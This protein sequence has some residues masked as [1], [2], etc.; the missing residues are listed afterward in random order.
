MGNDV[1]EILDNVTSITANVDSLTTTLNGLPL[2]ATLAQISTLLGNIEEAT[3]QLN[4]CDN[5]DGKLLNDEQLYNQLNATVASLDSLL[6]DIRLN[7][8]RYINIK[9]F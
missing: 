9:V 5:T 1:P 7:P 6:V 3:A 4:K 2:D 8:K